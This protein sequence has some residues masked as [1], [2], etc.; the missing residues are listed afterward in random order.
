[1]SSGY[2]A[3]ASFAGSA[4]ASASAP[5]YTT[6]AASGAYASAAPAYTAGPAYASG[7]AYAAGPAYT[8]A[9]APAVTRVVAA[10]P[11]VAVA[12]A[13]ALNVDPNPQLIRK[14]PAEKVHY[15]QEVAVRFLKP[16]PPAPHG[17]IVI[18]QE[19]DV[20]AAPAPPL[21]VRQKPPAPL[22]I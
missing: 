12:A 11:A 18:K 5:A 6:V 10:A 14:K 1:M 20:Q 7:P 19:R 3:P 17:D 15:R 13:P 2:Y 8:V 9:A 21:L 4:V 22:G 16:P